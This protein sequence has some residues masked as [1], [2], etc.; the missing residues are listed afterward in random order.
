MKFDVVIIGGGLAGT[1][2]ATELQKSGLK[3]ILVADGLSLYNCPKNE[4]KA[5]GG[6]VLQ[7][8]RVVSGDFEDGR[9]L[10]VY[11]AKLGNEPLEAGQFVLATGKY[12]SRGL[13]ADM[14][15]VYEPL[16]NLDVEYDADRLSWFDPSFAAPQRFLE[17]GVKTSG[18]LALKGGVPIDNLYPAGEV[19]A[20]V[21]SAQGDATEQILNSARQAVRAIRKT[22]YAGE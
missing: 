5:A 9:L 16:F 7:G 14:D 3:C 6:T 11:T 10:R 4:F 19:L 8:D 20:G 22:D 21:S 18:A 17:F 12:F 13:V 15:K 2:A 1:S